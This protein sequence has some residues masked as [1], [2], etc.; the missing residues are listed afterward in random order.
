MIFWSCM[1]RL[2][3]ALVVVKIRRIAEVGEG[4]R[5]QIPLALPN[6]EDRRIAGRVQTGREDLERRLHRGDGLGPV[7]GPER[8]ADVLGP[9]RKHWPGSTAP[10]EINRTVTTFS[11]E[12]ITP[13]L[14]SRHREASYRDGEAHPTAGGV[15]LGAESAL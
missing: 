4:W 8:R 15:K 5:D 2:S 14:V 9:G 7:D 12:S 13:G 1:C 6:R 11:G 3:I 10:V